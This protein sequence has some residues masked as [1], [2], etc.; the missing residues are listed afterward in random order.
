MFA[1]IMRWRAALAAVLWIA[2]GNAAAQT[3]EDF[4]ARGAYL[5]RLGDCAACHTPQGARPFSGGLAMKTPFGVVHST[6]ITPDV[7][8]GIGSY[9]LDQFDR[10]LR[11][12]VA[13]DGHNLYPAMPYPSFARI[14]DDDV[15]ALYA[16]FMNGVAPVEKANEA[17]D[18]RWPFNLRFGLMFWNAVFLDDKPFVADAAHS[19]QWN[20]GAYLVQGLGHCGT[21]HTP[22]GLGLQEKALGDTGG[23]APD[24][25]SGST[26]DDWHAPDLRH[27]WPASDYARFLKTGR[28]DHAAAFGT[29]AEVVHFSSQNFGAEDLLAVGV[30]LESLSPRQAPT[31]PAS[32]S[33]A[34]AGHELFHTRG[35]LGYVQFCSSCHRLDG[36]GVPDFFPPLAGNTSLASRDATSLIHVVLTGASSPVTERFP[37]SFSM[38]A[39]SRLGD[40]ELADILGFVRR[41]WLGAQ[42]P[43]RPDDILAMRRKLALKSD[44]PEPFVAPRFAAMLDS[45]DAERLIRGMRLMIDTRALLPDHVGN[46]LNCSSCHLN[47]GTVAKAS[48]FVGVAALFP[49]YAPRAGRI[50]EF[51]DRI[52]ACFRRSENGTPLAK[53]SPDLE[54]M[55]AFMASMK[56]PV[57]PKDP[58]PGRGVGKLDYDRFPAPDARHGKQVYQRDCAICHGDKGEGHRLADGTLV[59][60][61]L[62]GAGSFNIG[63]GM[64]RSYT[65]AGF[66]KNNMPIASMTRFPVGAGS[67][68]DQDALDVAEYF[69]RFSRPDFKDKKKDWPKGGKPKDARY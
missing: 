36:R 6:N 56:S 69:T 53:D 61:P 47:G 62:G 63:A 32:A 64:A 11:R 46:D 8:S 66:V 48:P 33:A 42:T 17:N 45:P 25:L 52:N 20:R 65:A 18:M 4:I 50:I 37:R 60:P 59:F 55:I 34:Q 19:A 44:A 39:Y 1:Q 12:G 3:G 29:M 58:I 67:L 24:F 23:A 41:Q 10:A 40:D 38:P 22:R 54:A 51:K 14:S 43:V 13:A 28:N 16:Y 2:A 26:L 15:K 5:A 68:D 31:G 7:K 30:Y 21:C 35:G 9:S 49:T 57:G 27:L